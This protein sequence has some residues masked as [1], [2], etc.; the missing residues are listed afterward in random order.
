MKSIVDR[1]ERSRLLAK[2]HVHQR[3]HPCGEAERSRVFVA[4][5]QRSGTNM[6]MD[7]LE[8]SLDT[9]V[10]HER[11]PRAFVN[12]RMRGT[13]EVQTLVDR[14]RARVFVIK[15]LCE[16][17]DLNQLMETFAPAKTIWIVRDYNDVVNSMLRS[18]RN[19][20]RQVNRIAND[21]QSDGWL[22][23]G[24]SDATHGIVATMAS[25]TLDDV[26][27]SALQ[28]YFRNM[29][30]FDQLFDS[31]S[32][33]LLVRYERVVSKPLEEFERIYNF[34]G[35]EFSP[36]IARKVSARSIGKHPRPEIAP[37]VRV[38]CDELLNRFHSVEDGE[39]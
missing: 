39:F 37:A 6:L 30:F 12:Y 17:Q 34:I 38:L 14:S 18:F 19:M 25:E 13:M 32:S 3:L 10:F 21:R 24:M 2:K 33:V 16:L 23:L 15:A 35:V 22:G 9:D 26:T 31:D 20:A 28:W 8:E 29:L 11:D 36:R 5:M 27:A 4:G 7:V 1:V